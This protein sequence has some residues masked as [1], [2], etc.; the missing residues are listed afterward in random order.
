MDD[1]LKSLRMSGVS[2]SQVSRLCGERDERVGA[3]LNRPLE[4]DWPNLCISTIYVKTREAGR[5]VSVATT[6]W[7]RGSSTAVDR[8]T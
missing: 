1:L 2:K 3:I 8:P 5:I 6:S 7:C 4:G